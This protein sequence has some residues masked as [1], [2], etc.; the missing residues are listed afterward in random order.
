MFAADDRIQLSFF[1]FAGNVDGKLL[2]RLKIVLGGLAVG[3][4]PLTIFADCPVE[5]NR[6][7]AVLAQNVISLV[8]GNGRKRLQQTLYGNKFVVG[9]VGD[10]FRFQQHRAEILCHHRLHAGAR[11]RRNLVQFGF[12]VTEDQRQVAAGLF[13]QAFNRRVF[14]LKHGLQ[15][16]KRRYVLM[17]AGNSQVNR[18]FY[19]FL[20]TCG[21]FFHIHNLLSL[22]L[23]IRREGKKNQVSKRK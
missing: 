18:A 15:Q 9:L 14:G 5:R 22:L 23:N 13:N 4:P 16:I 20:R 1:R 6:I 7:D 2:Q 17:P 12:R 3:Q 8:A 11:N 19:K 21:K 10:F